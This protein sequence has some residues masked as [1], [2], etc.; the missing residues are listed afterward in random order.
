MTEDELTNILAGYRMTEE[1]RLASALRIAELE[2][3][4]RA[5]Q[6]EWLATRQDVVNNQTWPDLWEDEDDESASEGRPDDHR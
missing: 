3:R 5:A 4:I 1:E 2:G 6:G